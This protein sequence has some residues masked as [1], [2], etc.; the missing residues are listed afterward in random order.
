VDDVDDDGEDEGEKVVEP[1]T[2][3][4]QQPNAVDLDDDAADEDW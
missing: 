2:T 1:T 4:K 3:K